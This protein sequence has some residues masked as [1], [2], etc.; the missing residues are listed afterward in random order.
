M[1]TTVASTE[2]TSYSGVRS[3]TSISR[4]TAL[5]AMSQSPGATDSAFTLRLDRTQS[6][7][8][9]KEGARHA[10]TAIDPDAVRPV[11]LDVV[12]VEHAVGSAADLAIHLG[13]DAGDRGCN[14]NRHP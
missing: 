10:V 9:R 7:E 11:D 13:D 6:V 12:G 3:E 8:R 2:A 5:F 4:S 14:A 1:S